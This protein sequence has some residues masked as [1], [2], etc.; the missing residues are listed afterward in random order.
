M[1][2]N[3]FPSFGPTFYAIKGFRLRQCKR[4]K[5]QERNATI[6]SQ[7]IP[8]PYS[9]L[10]SYDLSASVNVINSD[11]GMFNGMLSN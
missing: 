7:M 4:N 11:Y 10:K 8:P 2:K 1:V 5:L 6:C 9:F 3:D